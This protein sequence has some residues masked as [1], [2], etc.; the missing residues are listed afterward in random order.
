MKEYE[1][2]FLKIIK[3]YVKNDNTSIGI[4]G[5]D[6]II[7]YA[8]AHQ[9]DAI[10]YK[11]TRIEKLRNRFFSQIVS[12][13]SKQQ[14][15]SELLANLKKL[16]CFL[17]KGTEVSKYYPDPLLRSMGDIDLVVHPEDLKTAKEILELLG[18]KLIQAGEREWKYKRRGILLELHHSLAYPEV[19]DN[20]QINSF[21]DSCWNY[22]EENHLDP[23]FHFVYLLYHLRKHLLKSGVGLRQFIDVGMYSTHCKQVKWEWVNDAVSTIGLQVFFKQVMNFNAYWFGFEKPVQ[24]DSTPAV[25]LEEFAEHVIDDGIFGQSNPDNNQNLSVN[26]TRRKSNASRFDYLFQAIFWPYEYMIQ[27]PEYEFL[28]GK[29]YLLPLAWLKRVIIKLPRWHALKQ[30][31]L[32]KNGEVKKRDMYLK[33]WGL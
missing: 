15:A 28:V 11:Q 22:V 13:E 3:S 4:I 30:S 8:T 20:P 29:K 25:V 27:M 17:V 18:F 9:L 33:L 12:N 32:V 7:S 26:M 6:Q 24:C 31:Y 10:I 2:D 21:F 14:C 16:R 5:E 23:S 1:Y 19:F